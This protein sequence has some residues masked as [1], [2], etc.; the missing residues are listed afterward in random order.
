MLKCNDNSIYTGISNNLNRRLDTHAKGNGSKYVRARLPFKLIYI[1]EC[2]SRSK[3]IKREIEI[4]KLDKK[5]KKLL[6]KLYKKKEFSWA[7]LNLFL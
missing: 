2:P 1:E 7:F 5:I 4:K 3:A 6:V